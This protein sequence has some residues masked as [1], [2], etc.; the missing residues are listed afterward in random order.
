MDGR[1]WIGEVLEQVR[2]RIHRVRPMEGM[3]VIQKES[4]I[5][6]AIGMVPQQRGLRMDSVILGVPI[7]IT[8]HHMLH[9]DTAPNPITSP[10]VRP[11]NRR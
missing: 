3:G 10:I 2:V 1:K 6:L 9:L 8:R 11:P 5:S 7:R 4:N